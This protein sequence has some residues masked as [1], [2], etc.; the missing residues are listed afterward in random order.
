MTEMTGLCPLQTIGYSVFGLRSTIHLFL[1][2]S[3]NKGRTGTVRGDIPF[4]TRPF[5]F[6][7]RTRSRVGLGNALPPRRFHCLTSILKSQF[8]NDSILI[9]FDDRCH[10][11]GIADSDDRFE[12]F[13]SSETI[14]PRFHI[15]RRQLSR[16]NLARQMVE[17]D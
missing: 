2:L 5:R 6:N 7:D 3:R 15:P 13:I 10:T 14:V 12:L 9:D 8:P 16:T 17:V 1:F 4:L 11:R